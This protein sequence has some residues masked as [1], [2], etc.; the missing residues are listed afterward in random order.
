MPSPLRHPALLGARRAL[1]LVLGTV[2]A[3]LALGATARGAGLTLAETGAM[4][5]LVYAGTAQLAVLGLWTADPGAL[6]VAGIVVAT[7]VINARNLMLGVALAPW[8]GRARARRVYPA[9]LLLTEDAWALTAAERRGASAAAAREGGAPGVGFLVGAGAVLWLAWVASSVVGH[10]AGSAVRDPARWGLDFAGVAA[11]VVL[12]A[13][14]WR[15]RRDVPAWA[16]AGVVSLAAHAALPGQWYIVLGALAGS[17]A[18]VRQ[19][20]AAG[21]PGAPTRATRATRGARESRGAADA[22]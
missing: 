13:M 7:L 17:A 5:A 20:A 19:P 3:G 16:A 1:P 14:L 10:A 22:A 21:E 2:A 11:I 6:P 9:A 12:L 8:L 18:A 15:G 4:S